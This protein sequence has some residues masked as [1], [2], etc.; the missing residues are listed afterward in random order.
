MRF[1]SP[2]A[3][4]RA[5]LSCQLRTRACRVSR[6][7]ERVSGRSGGRPADDEAR[8]HRLARSC[9]PSRSSRPPRPLSPRLLSQ[10]PPRRHAAAPLPV[11]RP[12]LHRHLLLRRPPPDPSP[13]C[14][15]AFFRSPLAASLPALPPPQ[16]GDDRPVFPIGYT[17]VSHPPK[18]PFGLPTPTRDGRPVL[19][20]KD[21]EWVRRPSS[22]R[23]RAARSALRRLPAAPPEPREL[24]P[25]APLPFSSRSFT[26]VRCQRRPLRR[27]RTCLGSSAR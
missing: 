22:L 25:H 27:R 16:A 10:S 3:P 7:S 26:L 20:V 17:S 23:A 5:C 11:A 13:S 1:Q 15:V 4:A 21:V 2:A 18:R 14:M 12:V 8:R 9:C 6:R 24:T 19:E